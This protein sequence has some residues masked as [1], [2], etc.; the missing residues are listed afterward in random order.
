MKKIPKFGNDQPLDNYR[1]I[2]HIHMAVSQEVLDIWKRKNKKS[3]Q[4]TLTGRPELD[5][6]FIYAYDNEN[7]DFLILDIFGPNAHNDHNRRNTLF[8]T[9]HHDIVTP[10]INGKITYQEEP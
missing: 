7:K 1:N 2:N 4:K 9:L 5:Y 3:D 10:W 6:W 8:S